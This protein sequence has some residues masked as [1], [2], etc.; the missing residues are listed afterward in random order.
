MISNSEYI[1]YKI[2]GV[3]GFGTKTINK[4]Y[5]GIRDQNIGIT[6]L[7]DF[8]KEE[9]MNLGVN[10]SLYEAWKN[11]ED[12]V[13]YLDYER[14]IKQEIKLITP[15]LK[16]YPGQLAKTLNDNAPPLLFCLGDKNLL[17]AKNVAIIGAR[18]VTDTGNE[19]ARD[20]TRKL[21]QKGFNIVSGY[22]KGV[23]SIAHLT[24]LE[25]GGTTT[26][27]LSHGIYEFRQ[28]REFLD[29]PEWS[30]NTL[31]LSQFAPEVKW[32]ARNAMIRNETIVGLSSAVV[33]IQSGPNKDSDNKMSGTF[34]S[35]KSALKYGVP[36][37]VLK[38]ELVENAHGNKELIMRGAVEITPDNIL[39]IMSDHTE[40]NL[41]NGTGEQLSFIE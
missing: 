17:N 15:D 26:I 18:D 25:F 19:Y 9:F 16:E 28:K 22:A 32:F 5:R 12:S 14:L 3:E 38:P 6:N 37:Y 34:A 41:K 20:I 35:G 31:V 13:C 8:S 1:W 11:V 23:D 27:V 29:I 2:F 21:T 24:A 4:I 39:Q 30:E 7:E 10:E 36:L 33:V 40:I